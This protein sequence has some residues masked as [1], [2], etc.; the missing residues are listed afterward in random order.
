MTEPIESSDKRTVGI[1][2][3][4]KSLAAVPVGGVCR[5]EVA[6]QRVVPRQRIAHP[7]Q[8]VAARVGLDA[9]AVDDGVAVAGNGQARASGDV[10]L[11]A[12]WKTGYRSQNQAS[13]GHVDRPGVGKAAG[14]HGHRATVDLNLPVVGHAVAGTAQDQ[15]ADG[16]ADRDV[17]ADIE[18]AIGR[19]EIDRLPGPA[20][21]S[22]NRSRSSDVLRPC[23]IQVDDRGPAPIP[24]VVTPQRQFTPREIEAIGDVEDRIASDL[25][26]GAQGDPVER[27]VPTVE[28]DLDQRIARGAGRQVPEQRAA[29]EVQVA[30]AQRQDATVEVQRVARGRV[31][32]ATGQAAV[33]IEHQVEL[34]RAARNVGIE[35]DAV[36]RIERERRVGTG[37]LG[38]RT[39]Q[40]D[41]AI[42]RGHRSIGP[43][44]DR[45]HDDGRCRGVDRDVG[46]V[47]QPL[48]C[49]AFGGRRVDRRAC[50]VHGACRGLDE[51][52]FAAQ[53][54][55][56]GADAAV[57]LRRVFGP[58]R[59]PAA[60]ALA[61]RVDDGLIRQ[62]HGLAQQVDAAATASCSQQLPVDQGI[63]LGPEHHLAAVQAGGG[64]LDHA[65]VPEAAG[66]DADRVAAQRTEVHGRVAGCL[67]VQRD[68]FQ[69]APRDLHALAR[70]Q[71]DAAAIGLQQ[72]G[73]RQFQRRGDQHDVATARDDVALHRDRPRGRGTGC[74]IAK[75]P[76]AGQRVGVAH[77]QCRGREAGRVHHGAG[78]DG[79]ARLVHQHDLAVGRQ[80][81]EQLRRRGRDDAVQ[82]QAGGVGLGKV[83]AVAG[84][85]G[86]ALPVDCRVVRPGAVACGHDQRIGVRVREVGLPQNDDAT[87]G[88]DAVRGPGRGNAPGQRQRKR[89]HPKLR[90]AGLAE[91]RGADAC[92]PGGAAAVAAFV[93][94]DGDHGAKRPIPYR[95]VDMV[96]RGFA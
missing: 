86:K 16:R 60:V 51:A 40:A 35:V 31:D 37:R 25:H 63:A 12:A 96:E 83:G 17:C 2:D 36:A 88:Q 57:H 18:V 75:A 81:A 77:G 65:A 48:P 21:G 84:S 90:A 27:R 53:G 82:A 94:R 47:N 85:Y 19:I 41:A 68:A 45:A 14:S 6:A 56:F 54:P 59:N 38:D 46:R 11:A 43:A 72:G 73:S 24:I 15:I 22:Q 49:L 52:A 50:Q 76:S 28:R 69:A 20:V 74:R 39:G 70:R 1:A 67:Q 8:G 5:V 87:L 3:R 29:V 13:T 26:P 32:L 30:V 62:G 33:R 91:A 44:V 89:Q 58:N 95:A 93:L 80:R 42:G 10:D 23:A 79:D 92:R 61:R 64:R 4:R 7:L 78:A 34:A 71:H 66:K 55:A 9:Q